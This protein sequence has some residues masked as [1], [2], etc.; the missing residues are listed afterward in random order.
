MTELEEARECLLCPPTEKRILFCA[1]INLHGTQLFSQ[2]KVGG[3]ASV[4]AT[5][6]EPYILQT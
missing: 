5:T 1:Q 3:P 4:Y 6:L 2:T